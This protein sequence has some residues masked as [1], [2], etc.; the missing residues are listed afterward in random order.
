M[1]EEMLRDLLLLD[2]SVWDDYAFRHEP[3]IGKISDEQKSGFSQNAR[4]CGT[5]VAEEFLCL[6]GEKSPAAYVE[7]LGITLDFIESGAD[8]VTFAFFTEPDRISVSRG[9][10]DKANNLLGEI[11]MR[12]LFGDVTDVAIAHE[13]YHFIECTQED[14]YTNQKLLQLWKLGTYGKTSKVVSVSEIGAMAFAKRLLN[15][16]YCPFIL[17]VLMLYVRNK[18]MGKSL[19]DS[20]V[21]NTAKG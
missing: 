3:L 6:H 18:R 8:E 10:A 20:I 5:S 4:Q 15:L 16:S 1:I 13:L 7:K 19:Y 2:E 12:A 21:K 14:L 11:G 9:A 17:D